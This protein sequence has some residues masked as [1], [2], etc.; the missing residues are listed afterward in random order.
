MH[1]VPQVELVMQFG[2]PGARVAAIRV[3]VSADDFQGS[4]L[5][6]G[7]D[8]ELQPVGPDGKL[9]KKLGHLSVILY[10]FKA[11]TRS[12]K[13]RE[14]M[15]WHVPASRMINLW[16]GGFAGGR[17]RMK[18]ALSARPRGKYVKMEGRFTTLDGWTFTEL[19]TAG[20]DQPRYRWLRK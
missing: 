11:A 13:G 4:K 18:L 12:G 5:Y 10:R 17:Y 1:D 9:V 19:R 16:T 14:L 6:D 15:R 20:I 8:F 2:R 7:F 3:G